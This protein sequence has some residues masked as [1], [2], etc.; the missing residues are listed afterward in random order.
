MKK[1]IVKGQ[2]NPEKFTEHQ[3]KK[4]VE[5][6]F[7]KYNPMTFS[8]YNP[9]SILNQIRHLSKEDQKVALRKYN[10]EQKALNKK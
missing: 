10:A 9:D 2:E 1:P 6:D 3:T 8:H 5:P 4:A 7:S